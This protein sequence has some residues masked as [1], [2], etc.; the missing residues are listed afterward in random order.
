MG[1]WIFDKNNF[2]KYIF[3]A[4][5][6]LFGGIESVNAQ[7][8]PPPPPPVDSMGIDNKIFTKVDVEAA[9]QGGD[10]GWRKYLQQNLEVDKITKKI[11]IPRGEKELRQ[12][13]I[14]KFIVSMDGTISDVA[15]ES[16]DINA[17]CIAEAIRVIKT[18]PKWIPAKQNG[19]SVNAYRRQPISFVFER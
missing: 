8:F 16:N 7:N 19:R 14:V 4:L 5:V 13:V 17:A 12:T 10:V 1:L 2:M 15:A 11:K 18:S 3:F 6:V 9:F